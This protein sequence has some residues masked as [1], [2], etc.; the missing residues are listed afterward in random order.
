MSPGFPIC[1]QH[2]VS[3]GPSNLWPRQ[4][5]DWASARP[6]RRAESSGCTFCPRGGEHGTF[7]LSPG[8]PLRPHVSFSPPL[9]CW[10]SSCDRFRPSS[11]PLPP[12]PPPPHCVCPGLRGLSTTCG[13]IQVRHSLL[14]DSRTSAVLAACSLPA[15]SFC[16]QLFFSKCWHSQSW[17]LFFSNISLPFSRF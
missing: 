5:G 3:R 16:G 10:C 9:P 15:V 12:P 1:P 4:R 17:L 8:L 2:T 6:V 14:G 13:R 11:P 7:S